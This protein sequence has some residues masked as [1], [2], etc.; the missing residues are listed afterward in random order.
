LRNRAC[1]GYTDGMPDSTRTPRPTAPQLRVLRSAHEDGRVFAPESM[2]ARL[3]GAG[4]VA[5]PLYRHGR[6]HSWA[7]ITDAGRAAVAEAGSR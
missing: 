3:T 2:I 1:V 5:N 6:G 7:Q 4:L